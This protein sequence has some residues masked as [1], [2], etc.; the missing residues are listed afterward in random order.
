M[1][2]TDPGKCHALRPGERKMLQ[3]VDKYLSK[4]VS[5]LAQWGEEVLR[6]AIENWTR[7]ANRAKSVDGAFRIPTE[8]SVRFFWS[9]SAWQ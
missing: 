2:E 8:P 5:G 4:G 1:E 9:T 3:Y 7:F 6:Y